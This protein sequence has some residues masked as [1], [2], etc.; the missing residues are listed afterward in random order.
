MTFDK[1]ERADK[2][3]AD[4]IPE[5]SH[6]DSRLVSAKLFEE[7]YKS[8]LRPETASR[9]AASMPEKDGVQK[10]ENGQIKSVK[11]GDDYYSVEYDKQGNISSITEQFGSRR[12]VLQ[13]GKDFDAARLS[14]DGTLTLSKNGKVQ[15]A[16]TLEGGNREFKYDEKGQLVQ[17]LDRIHTN[18]GRD[19]VETTT[20]I[21]ESN[22]WDYRSNFGASGQRTNVV[23]DEKGDFRA[24]TIRNSRPDD[25]IDKDN[26]D[27]L[28][29]DLA[30]ARQ[31]LID[32][33]REKGLGNFTEQWAA[34]FEQ[35][36]RDLGHRNLKTATD[37]QIAKTYG[38]LEKILTE[39]SRI[40]SN[41]AKML[42]KE[43]LK[44]YANPTKYV[45]QGGHPTCAFAMTERHVVQTHPDD[46]ARVLYEAITN[47]YVRS[48]DG[49]KRIKLADIQIQPDR[50]SRQAY[51]NDS[52]DVG[53]WSYSNKIFQL[54]AT[55][56]GYGG[57][58]GNGYD[59][60]GGTD[61]QT[62]RAN[63]FITG[64]KDLFILMNGNTS[65][66]E[67]V[68]AYLKKHGTLGL[69]DYIGGHAMSITDAKV[70]DGKKYIYIDNSWNGMSEGWK[71]V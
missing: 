1:G 14:E 10:M 58:R 54:T 8:L 15:E 18:S 34:K 21:G 35:R 48:K 19:L 36:C 51:A 26:S 43:A 71:R 46:H 42:F 52:K 68:S 39:R 12:Q 63:T 44:S 16:R 28:H 40:S 27:A 17:I 37:E 3:P 65:T 31:H 13:A 56:I 9:V 29:T 67:K 4:S 22:V 70:K 64:K 5:S 55:A 24:D 60:Y 7:V 33:A 25:L 50:E 32:I 41:N 66:F 62:K 45:N 69:F 59:M 11:K 23:V 61:D 30:K 57:Y 38:Y 6:L 53:A 47:Q 49:R 20:R 2:Q